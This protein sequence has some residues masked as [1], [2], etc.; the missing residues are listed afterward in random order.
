MITQQRFTE[1]LA[2]KMTDEQKDFFALMY[3]VGRKEE[4]DV[5]L[6][7]N[8]SAEENIEAYLLKLDLLLEEEKK[9]SE[10]DIAII[11]DI[12]SGITL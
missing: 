6:D 2:K 4:V 3:D 1:L 8:K 11:D 7:F 10:E 12:M 9:A 5:Q